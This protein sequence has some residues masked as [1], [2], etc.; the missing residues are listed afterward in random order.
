MH[1]FNIINNT[2]GPDFILSLLFMTYFAMVIASIML[3]NEVMIIPVRSTSIVFSGALIPYVF[4]YPIAFI[5]LRI[6]G[7]SSVH[8]MI[9][10]MILGSLVFVIVSKAVISLSSNP[11]DI[12]LILNNA[13]KMYLAGLVGMPAGIYFSF[14]S[15]HF[16]S[17]LGFG[18][19]V[20]SIFIATVMG[21][22]VNTVIVFPI[23]F[24]GVY[25]MHQLF[26]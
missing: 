15:L 13:F 14:L 16:L 2:K 4:L 23:G 7:L 8:N 1:K 9:W 25:N 6:Y 18:F 10:S 21:E 24:H 11:S 26:S 3:F 22:L 20:L 12:Y 5:V 17:K 19:N